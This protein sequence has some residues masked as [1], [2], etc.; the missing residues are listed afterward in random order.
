[1]AQTHIYYRVLVPAA[2][3]MM[4]LG[5][6]MMAK[7]GSAERLLK[8]KDPDVFVEKEMR[9]GLLGRV[10]HFLWQSGN[11]S[12]QPVWPVSFILYFLHHCVFQLDSL[13]L[14]I[15]I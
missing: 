6:V 14:S 7:V 5:L 9:Q 1:M 13:H 8:D 2:S 12:Y 10:A 15:H 3:W 4:F 11:S